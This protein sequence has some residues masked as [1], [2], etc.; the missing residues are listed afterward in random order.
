MTWAPSSPDL[1]TRGPKGIPKHATCLNV[2][3]ENICAVS[4]PTR[5]AEGA[6]HHSPSPSPSSSFLSCLSSL[7]VYESIWESN[8]MSWSNTE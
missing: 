4:G 5:A 7:E 3:A 8:T 2:Q 1:R 6:K